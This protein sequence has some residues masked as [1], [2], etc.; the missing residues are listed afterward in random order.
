MNGMGSAAT[1]YVIAKTLLVTPIRFLFS[2]AALGI[3]V[4]IVHNFP[5]SNTFG[6][7]IF[8]SGPS[9]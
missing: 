8:G 7:P 1:Y 9:V 2:L 6:H 4:F 3:P 5:P